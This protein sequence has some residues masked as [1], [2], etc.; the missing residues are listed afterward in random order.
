[1][2]MEIVILGCDVYQFPSFGDGRVSWAEGH[3]DGWVH[4]I[5]RSDVGSRLSHYETVFIHFFI[6]EAKGFQIRGGGGVKDAPSVPRRQRFATLIVSHR[7]IR[8][9]HV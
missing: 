2:E 5:E 4:G 3:T 6:A 9:L 1:M 7:A 8:C